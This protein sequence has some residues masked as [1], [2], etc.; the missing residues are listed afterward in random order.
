MTPERWQLYVSMFSESEFEVY[1][2]MGQ[3][4][5][6]EECTPQVDSI[7]VRSVFQLRELEE[8]LRQLYAIHEIIDE[9]KTET[10]EHGAIVG[11][12]MHLVT[13]TVEPLTDVLPEEIVKKGGRPWEL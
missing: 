9:T 12:W 7:R 2:T 6:D 3:V 10:V 13:S 8:R 11:N 5:V 1:E 4:V